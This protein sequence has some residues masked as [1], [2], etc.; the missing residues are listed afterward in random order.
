MGSLS[1]WWLFNPMNH[2]SGMLFRS[3]PKALKFLENHEIFFVILQFTHP[4]SLNILSKLCLQKIHVKATNHLSCT[5]FFSK[6]L[7]TIPKPFNTT[8]LIATTLTYKNMHHF[9]SKSY[10]NTIVYKCQKVNIYI[11]YAQKSINQEKNQRT[12]LLWISYLLSTSLA[13]F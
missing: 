4:P 7:F 6:A 2:F 1:I 13:L 11:V 10:K 8:K 3:P 5:T 12:S 9:A